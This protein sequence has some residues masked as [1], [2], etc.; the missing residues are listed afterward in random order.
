METETWGRRGWGTE[1]W[2]QIHEDRDNTP[3]LCIYPASL[4]SYT[5]GGWGHS[6]A[7]VRRAIAATIYARCQN[8]LTGMIEQKNTVPR[9]VLGRIYIFQGWHSDFDLCHYIY[10]ASTPRSDFDQKIYICMC[11]KTRTYKG[12]P[13]RAH[14]KS[15]SYSVSFC[16]PGSQS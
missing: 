12:A 8:L 2:R 1:A 14:Q 5:S 3:F 13:G 15:S 16:C 7:G 6:G 4:R 9:F 10:Y 11:P